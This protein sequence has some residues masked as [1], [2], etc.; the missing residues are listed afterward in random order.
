MPAPAMATPLIGAGQRSAPASAYEQAPARP[1]PQGRIVGGSLIA[2]TDAPWQVALR[3]QQGSFIFSCGGSILNA[4][5]ILTA[6]HCVNGVVAG[7]PYTSGGMQ[8]RAG[9]ADLNVGGGQESTVAQIRVNPRYDFDPNR[10][11][12]TGDLA[13]LTLQTP[14]TLDG[15]TARAIPL[16]T[17]WVPTST[18]SPV[19]T[20]LR[21]TGFGLNA[22]QGSSDGKLRAVGTT[23][24]ADPDR[25]SSSYEN[26]I[27]ICARS[28]GGSSCQGDSGGPLTTTGPSPVLVGV[29]SNGGRCGP[30]TDDFYVD[31]FAPEN[32]AFIDGAAQLPV[33]PRGV[34][35]PT[36]SGPQSFRVGDVVTCNAGTF[37]PSPTE[38]RL[39]FTKDDG[40]VLQSTIGTTAQFTL[41]ASAVGSH[42]SCRPYAT[43][44]GGTYV[45][46]RFT[47]ALTIAAAPTPP[48]STGGGGA[49][50]GG[51]SGASLA[52][53][54]PSA[55]EQ[56]ATFDIRVKAPSSARR[57]STITVRISRFGPPVGAHGV[58]VGVDGPRKLLVTGSTSF[59]ATGAA[60]READLEEFLKVRVR[61]PRG[62]TVGRKYTFNASMLVANT[63]DEIAGGGLC[64]YGTKRFKVRIKR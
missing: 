39:E 41:P 52:T 3:T 59:P 51:G 17:P 26:A 28:A 36:L 9:I 43:N 60:G 37:S 29:V 5:T 33:A 63:V 19:P 8:V 15:V 2:I 58:V 10:V 27:A 44:A 20:D 46:V 42:L 1:A 55:I 18:P 16:P 25:C 7:Q 56:A 50:S 35:E 31:L 32:R 54:C 13:V 64:E 34:T 47:T 23:S 45:G 30:D 12:T 4:T 61:V 57:G 24:V 62:L 11:A 40:T 21:V 22:D 38:V 53:Q 49:G 6:A 48:P 14:L